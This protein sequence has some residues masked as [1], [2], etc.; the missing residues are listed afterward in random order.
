MFRDRHGDL[1]RVQEPPKGSILLQLR[2]ALATAAK[3]DARLDLR[4][5]MLLKAEESV[6]NAPTEAD[7]VV[8]LRAVERAKQSLS[9]QTKRRDFTH[10]R[11]VVLLD[12]ARTRTLTSTHARKSV[13][14]ATIKALIARA[15]IVVD[16]VTVRR[17]LPSHE[18]DDA[19]VRLRTMATKIVRRKMWEAVRSHRLSE[20]EVQ[21]RVDVAVLN[22]AAQWDW[23]KK[24]AFTTY[25]FS[26]TRRELQTRAKHE[27]PILLKQQDDGNW[28]SAGSLS[29][30]QGEDGKE[31]EPSMSRA[32]VRHEQ[33]GPTRP[34]RPVGHGISEDVTTALNDLC[35]QDREIADRLWLRD[36][37]VK[38]VAEALN[39]SECLIRSRRAKI[40]EHFR[41][42][43]SD[44]DTESD[45]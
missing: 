26:K 17:P 7:R 3:Q 23:T 29:N 36:Q 20:D 39:L 25:A 11:M 8:A 4:R 33:S 28:T 31:F 22:A 32:F 16:V 38:E 14:V 27:R 42:A 2:R 43:L 15:Q 30:F 35:E 37:E 9:Y 18:R 13:G 24:A 1:N 44:Y 19:F 12:A 40:A 45:L 21:E 10:Q 5:E 6:V 41:E 34:A